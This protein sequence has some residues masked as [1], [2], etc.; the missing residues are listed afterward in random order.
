MRLTGLGRSVAEHISCG[1]FV[2]R[3]RGLRVL[4]VGLVGVLV[5]S[6]GGQGPSFGGPPEWS[7]PQGETTGLPWPSLPSE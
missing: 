6:V 1:G 5:A 3:A 4:V 7:P 2:R